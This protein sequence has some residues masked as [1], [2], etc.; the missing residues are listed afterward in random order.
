MRRPNVRT[1]AV[2]ASLL[3]HASLL[4]VAIRAAHQVEDEPSHDRPLIVRLIPKEVVPPPPPPLEVPPLRS[5]TGQSASAKA[6]PAQQQHARKLDK[7][8]QRLLKLLA[9]AKDRWAERPVG[10]DLVIYDKQ[11]GIVLPTEPTDYVPFVG[12]NAIQMPLMGEDYKRGDKQAFS[13][14]DWQKTIDDGFHPKP[15]VLWHHKWRFHSGFE[16][17]C[18]IGIPQIDLSSSGQ[19]ANLID[20]SCSFGFPPLPPSPIEEDFRL[21]MLPSP[22]AKEMAPRGAPSFQTCLKLYQDV[23]PMPYGCPVDMPAMAADVDE[24]ILRSC[25]EGY[26]LIGRVPKG[27]PKLVGNNLEQIVKD[28]DKQIASGHPGAAVRALMRTTRN[29][30]ATDNFRYTERPGDKNVRVKWHL[31]EEELKAEGRK[32]GLARYPIRPDV[33]S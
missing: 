26:R 5:Q 2:G 30:H 28:V 25:I 7:Q 29:P 16:I 11:G 27:C 19:M 18:E 12:K 6:S 24:A 17:E 10:E 3:L 31:S 9:T 32:H 21:N 23:Q 22:L 15:H 20:L 33:E 13:K 14:E 8:E 4:A 1:V